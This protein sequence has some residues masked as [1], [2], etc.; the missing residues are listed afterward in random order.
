MGSFKKGSATLRK[1]FRDGNYKPI[2]FDMTKYLNKINGSSVTINQ[3]KHCL[4]NLQSK[5]LSNDYNDY[6]GRAIH[7]KTLFN[8]SLSKFTTVEKWCKHCLSMGIRTIEDFE[9]ATYTCPQVQYML[10]K[11]KDTLSIN[12]NITP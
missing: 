12:C 5:F 8:N 10:H 1:V 9:H 3:M 4:K 6:K 11:V 7:G 2:Q